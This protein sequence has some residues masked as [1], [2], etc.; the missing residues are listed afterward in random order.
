MSSL[1]L[2][3]TKQCALAHAFT[4]LTESAMI[5]WNAE[6]IKLCFCAFQFWR[7]R[8]QGQN[9][10]GKFGCLQSVDFMPWP[11]PITCSDFFAT[12]M[13]YAVFLGI[14]S[15]QFWHPSRLRCWPQAWNAGH[16]P[17]S[18][19]QRTY[20]RSVLFRLV[21]I[22]HRR[23]SLFCTERK[24]RPVARNEARS[25]CYRMFSGWPLLFRHGL[26]SVTLAPTCQ[27]SR[28]CSSQA[29]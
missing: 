11:L 18:Q 26:P 24:S 1:V 14:V 23:I 2:H 28:S 15:W 29:E 27:L 16:S 6:I 20:S 12:I 19:T 8:F 17:S 25:S 5:Q 3:Q 22:Q 13:L 7:N 4:E 21:C 9:E 10:L